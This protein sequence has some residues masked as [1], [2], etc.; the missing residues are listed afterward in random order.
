M[1]RQNAVHAA[2]QSPCRG[3][4]G[5][6]TRP[7]RTCGCDVNFLNVAKLAWKG[8][9]P[10]QRCRGR[11]F[12]PPIIL[13]ATSC[14]YCSSIPVHCPPP[15]VSCLPTPPFLFSEQQH[16][17]VLN[18]VVGRARF[19]NPCPPP[20]FAWFF[21]SVRS[22]FGGVGGGVAPSSGR[23]GTVQ[24]RNTKRHPEVLR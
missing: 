22:L 6:S 19:N 7:M 17:G 15:P 13:R 12:F 2:S 21:R 16:I 24:A 11:S 18:R 14:R 9:V 5:E 20:G 23:E 10:Q 3:H 4:L 8:S 1:A